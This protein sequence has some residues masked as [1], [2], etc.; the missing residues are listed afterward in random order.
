MELVIG[1]CNFTFHLIESLP[2]YMV[3]DFGKCLVDR[4]NNYI[5]NGYCVAQILI[6]RLKIFS[7]EVVLA[8]I[9]ITGLCHYE[10][11]YDRCYF[12]LYFCAMFF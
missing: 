3:P 4:K 12:I 5:Q 7:I 11:P 8:M 1:Q 6:N 10:I 9:C 2:K